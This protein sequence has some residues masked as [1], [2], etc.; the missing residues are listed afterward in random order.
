MVLWPTEVTLGH[1]VLFRCQPISEANWISE[2]PNRL[3][4]GLRDLRVWE[5]PTLREHNTQAVMI[6]EDRRGNDYGRSGQTGQGKRLIIVLVR[7]LRID[8][9]LWYY[10]CLTL[11]YYHLDWV[12]LITI[13]W[14]FVFVLIVFL[15]MNSAHLCRE[16]LGKISQKVCVGVCVICHPNEWWSA[17]EGY[18]STMDGHRTS[19][20][21]PTAEC[22]IEI[23]ISILYGILF[24]SF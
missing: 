3:E 12:F 18:G 11:I 6:E 4:P 24:Y 10:V 19:V 5:F 8:W 9:G 14:V 20:A 15:G 22:V 13:F 21:L 23:F 2:L 16:L 1:R 7:P 17:H